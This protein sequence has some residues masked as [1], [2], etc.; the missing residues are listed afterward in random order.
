MRKLIQRMQTSVDG[1]VGRAGEGPAWQVWD[2][3]DKAD[4]AC[5][6]RIVDACYGRAASSAKAA[7]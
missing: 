6:Q 7:A 1:Y 3:G 2:Y 4:F 5:A